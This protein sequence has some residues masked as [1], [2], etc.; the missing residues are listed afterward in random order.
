[1]AD[2][3]KLLLPLTGESLSSHEY[4]D[5]LSQPAC[6]ISDTNAD[7]GAHIGFLGGKESPDFDQPISS[8]FDEGKV[9]QMPWCPKL[10]YAGRKEICRDH[11][12]GHY[13]ARH[14]LLQLKLGIG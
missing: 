14:A 5:A 8:K 13:M 7:L 9:W 3:Q 11:M 1:M 4:D 12:P 2:D 10:K 6:S